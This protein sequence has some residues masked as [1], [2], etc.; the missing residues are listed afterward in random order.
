[1]GKKLLNGSLLYSIGMALVIVGL[2]LPIVKVMG[3]TPNAFKFLD[4][5]NFGTTTVAI[6]LILIGAALGIL[7][8]LINKLSAKS[9]KLIA[10]AITLAGG[11]ILLLLFT[12][13]LS[14]SSLGGKI[15]RAAGK[16]FIKHAY[17]G[18]YVILVGWLA[19]IYGWLTGN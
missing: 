19:A 4:M 9:N 16:S 13:I 8:S 10:L 12:G 15:M 7:F 18:F 11:V 1:M 17:I 6:L 5:K 14:D 3:Q 2:L